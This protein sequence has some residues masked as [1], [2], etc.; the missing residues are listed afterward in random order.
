MALTIRLDIVSAHATIF[1][2][3]VEAVY[4]TAEEGEVGILHGHAPLLARLKP[5]N[6]RAVSAGQDEQVFYVSGGMIEVQPDMVTILADT[7]ARAEDLDEAAAIEAKEQAER[8]LQDKTGEFE[9][10]EA[11]S[12]LAEA[13]AQLH[14]IRRLR[15]KIPDRS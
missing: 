10:T 8:A 2:G 14:A 3:S 4:A 13:A 6:I 12:T 9:Y 1:S 15:R 5:G 11:L 7:A